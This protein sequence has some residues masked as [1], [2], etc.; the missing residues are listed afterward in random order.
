MHWVTSLAG[1]LVW[2]GCLHQALKM[3][4][5]NRN[6]PVHSDGCMFFSVCLALTRALE[7]C[8][9]RVSV[10]GSSSSLSLNRE[11]DWFCNNKVRIPPNSF[12]I[13]CLPHPFLWRLKSR[14]VL[15]GAWLLPAVVPWGNILPHVKPRG[16]KLSYSVEWYV[17]LMKADHSTS[18]CMQ[19]Y[20]HTSPLP[21]V[22]DKGVCPTHC[23]GPAARQGSDQSS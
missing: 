4:S 1:S 23:D 8:W 21:P 3:S 14:K 2:W 18:L 20:K 5:L 13:P 9:V 22:G 16:G 11:L 10:T 17:F 7:L 6:L 19:L 15:K 12:W